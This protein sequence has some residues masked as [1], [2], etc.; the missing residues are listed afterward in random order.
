MK[1]KKIIST[2]ISIAMSFAI[3]GTTVSAYESTDAV[4]E[5]ENGSEQTIVIDPTQGTK[6]TVD[7]SD[8]DEMGISA[9]SELLLYTS[10]VDFGSSSSSVNTPVLVTPFETGSNKLKFTPSDFE[11]DKKID[12]TLYTHFSWDNSSTWT[13]HELGKLTFSWIVTYKILFSGTAASDV[14]KVYLEFTPHSDCAKSFSYK[15]SIV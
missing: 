15:V 5:Q 9:Y 2:I 11:G 8:L 7:M 14:D 6:V 4:S 1:A 10:S 13:S 12:V 3:L